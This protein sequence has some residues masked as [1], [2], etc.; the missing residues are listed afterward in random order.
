MEKIKTE[1]LALEIG[2]LLRDTFVARIEEENGELVLQFLSGQ[3]FRVSVEE[4][5]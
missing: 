4:R 5:A 1:A 3:K 2:A